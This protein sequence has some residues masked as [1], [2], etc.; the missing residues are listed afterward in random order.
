MVLVVLKSAGTMEPLQEIVMELST[1]AAK[2]KGEERR[3]I[4]VQLSIFSEVEVTFS[5]L[6]SKSDKLK[7]QN[8][9]LLE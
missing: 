1:A 4:C 7:I 2:L 9:K 3:A 8:K 6:K 5:K